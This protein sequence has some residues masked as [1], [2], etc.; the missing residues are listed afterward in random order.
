MGFRVR[1]TFLRGAIVFDN[2]KVVG[3]PR[4]R[5]LHRPTS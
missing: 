3:A 4:G 5:Y 2:G 1:T